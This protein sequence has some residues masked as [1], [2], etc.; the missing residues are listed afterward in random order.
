MTIITSLYVFY[1]NLD[2]KYERYSIW[3]ESW[4]KPESNGDAQ[5]CPFWDSSSQLDVEIKLIL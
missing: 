3:R 2:E 1:C 5:N 4:T